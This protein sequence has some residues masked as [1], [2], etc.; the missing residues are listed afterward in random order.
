MFTLYGNQFDEYEEHLLLT[1][2]QRVLEN[3]FSNA[4]NISGLLRANTA[5]TRMMTT[6]TRRSAGQHYLK[7]TL[8]SVLSIITAQSNLILEINPLKVYEQMINDYESTTGKLSTLPRKPLPEEAAVNPDVVTLI[9]SRVAELGRITDSFISALIDSMAR[10]P[11]GIR[12]ICKQIRHL[13]MTYFPS[14]TEAQICSMVGGFFLLRFVNP[15]IV[16]PQAFMLVDTKLSTPAR[17]NLT[18][19]AKIMQNMANNVKFGGVKEGY[20]EPLNVVLDRNR[21]R[22]N[23]FLLDLTEVEDLSQVGGIDQYIALGKTDAVTINI[24]LNEMYFIHSLLQLNLNSLRK[25]DESNNQLLTNIMKQIGNAPAQLPRKD[26]ANVDLELDK[27]IKR[28]V[29]TEDNCTVDQT[30]SETKYLLF[31]VLK[32]LVEQADQ[33]QSIDDLLRLGASVAKRKGNRSLADH[34]Q[35]ITENCRDLEARGLLSREDDYAALRRDTAAEMM[36]HD[37]LLRQTKTDRARLTEVLQS[38]QNHHSFLQEQFNAYKEYLEN[39]RQ[40]SACT[41]KNKKSED[42]KKKKD[43]AKHKKDKPRGP[44]KYSHSQLEK[45]GIIVESEAPMD[46]RGAIFFSFSSTSPGEFDVSVLFARRTIAKMQLRLDD[47]L[48]RQHA[49]ELLFETEFLKL[50]INLLLHLLNK[51][52]VS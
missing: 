45:D 4:K 44:F 26:N 36:N 31:L 35:Q 11:Y 16:T 28:E 21:D 13:M 8:T 5:L 30:Y 10:T 38:I 27:S 50:N 51:D 52:F 7:S 22:M 18:L 3:E 33:C 23:N 47:L 32:A 37:T 20:M 49:N 39:V 1:M 34:V 25:I 40:Q 6:Y 42:K 41:T 48:E 24:S 12:W 14:A 2:F 46:R 43:K 19:L 9:N 29:G 15:A 17:R